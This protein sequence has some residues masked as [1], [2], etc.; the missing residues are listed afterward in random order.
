MDRIALL[1]NNADYV[2]LHLHLHMYRHSRLH[3]TIRTS[4]TRHQD[5]AVDGPPRHLLHIAGADHGT[6]LRHDRQR[7]CRHRAARQTDRQTASITTGMPVHGAGDYGL[8]G[9]QKNTEIG[10]RI[11]GKGSM[12]R[13]SCEALHCTDR[14]SPSK[15]N[16][17]WKK[18]KTPF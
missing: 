6:P 7:Q 5:T 2:H 12:N 17:V 11:D 9:H 18:N 14:P 4:S 8:H 15:Y 16:A 1:Y 13:R 3:R 10:F